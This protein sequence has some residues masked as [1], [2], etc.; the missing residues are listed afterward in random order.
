MQG[1]CNQVKL[2][3]LESDRA[4]ARYDWTICMVDPLNIIGILCYRRTAHV[5]DIAISSR[6]QLFDM[7]LLVGYLLQI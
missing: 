3:D 1:S 5:K 6:E 4:E 2:D 7:E